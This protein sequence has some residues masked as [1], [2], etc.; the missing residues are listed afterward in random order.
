MIRVAIRRRAFMCTAAVHA[1]ART[2]SGK[3]RNC[4]RSPS[5][6]CSVES[7]SLAPRI[8]ES[9]CSPP[10]VRD[11]VF[12]SVRQRVDRARRSLEICT[13]EIGMGCLG[14]NVKGFAVKLGVFRAAVRE[15]FSRGA[16]GDESKRSGATGWKWR[17]QSR[18]GGVQRM[19]EERW[20]FDARGSGVVETEVGERPRRRR[21]G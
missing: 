16:K 12:G 13:I 3:A 2:R 10:G 1:R 7:H 5:S 8:R 4:W 17:C 6:V 19:V 9:G 14:E 20:R 15:W 11:R 21:S 18:S